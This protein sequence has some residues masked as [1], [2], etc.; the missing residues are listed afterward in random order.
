MAQ[1]RIYL[2][3]KHCGETCSIA[4]F[5]SDTGWFPSPNTAHKSNEG[6]DSCVYGDFL[7]KHSACGRDA[8]GGEDWQPFAFEYE[9]SGK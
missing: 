2:K 5:Y 8:S 9:D 7:E 1:D 6:S 3:C 4:K